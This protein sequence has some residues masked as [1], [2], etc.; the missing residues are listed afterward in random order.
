MFAFQHKLG[1]VVIKASRIPVIHL[2]TLVTSLTKLA[3]VNILVAMAVNTRP[4][5]R[6][7]IGDIARLKMA[8]FAAHLNMF[9]LQ[10]KQTAGMIKLFTERFHPI[11]T[12]QADFAVGQHMLAG[13]SLIQL[14]VTLRTGSL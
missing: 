4:R 5:G 10:A 13:E 2:M 14:Q 11:M 6:F 1:A 8:L 3:I 7:E 9:A 12:I